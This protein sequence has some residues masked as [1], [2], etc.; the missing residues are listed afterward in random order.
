MLGLEKT[1]RALP[2]RFFGHL[3]E[4]VSFSYNRL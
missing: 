1:Q 3:M 4:D 2:I